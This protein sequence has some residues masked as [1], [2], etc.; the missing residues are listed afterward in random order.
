MAMQLNWQKCKGDVWCGLLTVDLQHSHFDNR[1]GVYIIWH[2]G[3]NPRTVR[4]GQGDIRDRLG[5]HRRD[6][7]VLAYKE[8]GLYATWADVPK[9]SQDGVER[10]LAE[11]LTPMVGQIFPEAEAIQVNL[12]P[13]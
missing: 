11:Q 8:H 3:Q 13:W 6:D 12:P 1:E 9:A 10:Y 2:G 5:A 4:V 7:A